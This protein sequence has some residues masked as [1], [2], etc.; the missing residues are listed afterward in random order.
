V[1][2]NARRSV[3]LFV[4]L[5]LVLA[6]VGSFGQQ[7]YLHQARLLRAKDAVVIELAAARSA[8]A[9]IQGPLAVS[10]WARGRGMVPAPDVA[11][12]IPVAPSPVPPPARSVQPP[13]LEV[14]T[15]WR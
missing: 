8:A 13:T 2:R 9:A 14:R 7:R 6:G 5:V 15:I 3:G 4:V 1:T 12:V 10:H 11:N